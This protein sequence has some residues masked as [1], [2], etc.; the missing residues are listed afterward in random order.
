V[1]YAT[2]AV[3]D[4]PERLLRGDVTLASLV[5][6]QLSR[7][8]DAG[9]QDSSARAVVLGGAPPAPALLERAA[10]ARVR[11]VETYGMTETCSMVTIDGWPVPGAD[12][13][14]ADDR[15]ILVRGPMVARPGGELRTGDLGR[16]DERGRLLVTGRKSDTIVTGAE[17][18]APTEVEAVLAAHPGVADAAVLGRPDAEWGEAIVALIVPAAGAPP[19]PAELR[20]FCRARLAAFKVPKAFELVDALPRTPSGKLLRRELH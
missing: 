19:D 5:P 1:I 16:F 9:L 15:E 2:T 3:I 20:E 12:I 8:L 14:L 17:N 6:T 11:V 4:G 18:V 13:Q 10:A 7:L